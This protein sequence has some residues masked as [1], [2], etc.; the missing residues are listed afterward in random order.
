M[1][2][3][4]KVCFSRVK[5]LVSADNTSSTESEVLEARAFYNPKEQW[6]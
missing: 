3:A 5:K 2:S 4:S 1:N 6:I